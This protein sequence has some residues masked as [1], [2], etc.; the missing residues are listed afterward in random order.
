MKLL[1]LV[2]VQAQMKSIIL[3]DMDGTLGPARKPVTPDVVSALRKLTRFR[4]ATVGIVTG[5]GMDYVI[6]Q[7]TPIWAS[8]NSCNP[9]NIVLM[10]CNGTQVFECKSA[11]AGIYEET[12]AVSVIEKLKKTKYKKLISKLLELQLDVV[13]NNKI[14]LT[15]EFISYRKSLINWCPIGRAASDEQREEFIKLDK[16]NDIRSSQLDILRDFCSSKK[17]NVTCSLGGQTSIDIYPQGWDKSYALK[18]AGDALCWF[19]GDKCT[20]TGNDKQIYDALVDTGRAFQTTGPEE[21]VDI[22]L[23]KIIPTI[24]ET[25]EWS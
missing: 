10:P 23:N 25:E 9:E 1:Q 12:H 3:F 20:G 4:R 24:E 2:L 7:C 15:G 17:I 14:P 8:G 11:A 5:S 21:T 22:I 18:H 6:E 19:V 16:E 13:S